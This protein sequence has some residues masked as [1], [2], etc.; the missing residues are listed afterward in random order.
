MQEPCERAHARCVERNTLAC[1]LR[2]EPSLA[3]GE[4]P[5]IA[6]DA[7]GRDH[8]GDH[9]RVHQVD[10]EGVAPVT[11]LE[12]HR[13]RGALLLAAGSAQTKACDHLCNRPLRAVD[14]AR[15]DVDVVGRLS[16]EI[17]R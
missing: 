3:E 1:Y 6:I 5:N 8:L 11:K 13:V 7:R 17:A 9:L 16:C 15:G 4:V 12:A 10:L 14:I 2:V